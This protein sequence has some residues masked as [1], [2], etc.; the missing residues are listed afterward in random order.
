M[1]VRRAKLR[2]VDLSRRIRSTSLIMTKGTLI[3]VREAARD[4]TTI[5]KQE[6]P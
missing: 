4:E 6:A 1:K 2:N 5:S 3:A